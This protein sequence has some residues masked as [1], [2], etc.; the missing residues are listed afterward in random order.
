MQGQNRVNVA[1]DGT[2]QSTTTWRGY[3][4]VDE[5][6]YIDADLIG[7]V[8]IEKGP[9]GG[10]TGAGITGGV[11]SMRTL[12]AGDIVKDGETIGGRFRIGTS[13]NAIE[14][15]RTNSLTQ[16]TDAPGFFD[17]ANGSGS[18]AVAI[19][20]ENFEFVA[21]AAR[22]K[23]GNYFTGS[24]GPTHYE[25]AWG[26][27]YPLSYTQPGE[28]MFNSSEDTFSSLI[29]S[30]MRWDAHTLELGYMHF[31]S[32]FGE[33]LGSLLTMGENSFRQVKLATASADTYTARYRW[34]PGDDMFDVRANIWATDVSAV[35]RSVGG[36]WYMDPW[37]TPEM[38]PPADD[39]RY[40]ETW[41]YGADVTNTSRFGTG[42]G[43]VSIDYG[44]SYVLEDMDGKPYYSR[45]YERDT[46]VIMNPSIGTREVA[47]LFT[48]GTLDVTDWLQF[49]GGLRYDAYRITEKGD[50]YS[51][52]GSY[53][54]TYADQ[55]GGRLNPSLGVTVT[56]F[57]GAQLYALYSE[58]VRPPS[59][60]ETIGSDSLFAPNPHLRA[61]IAKNWEVGANYQRDGLLGDDD[62]LGLKLSYFHNTYDDYIARVSN[63]DPGPGRPFYAAGNL[64]SASF[65]GIELSGSYE[66]GPVFAQAAI[67]HYL[68][69]EFCE[70]ADTC[71]PTAISNDYA[72]NHLPPETAASLTLG[73]KL[74]DDKLTVGGRVNYAGGRLGPPPSSSQATNYWLPYTVVDAFL[75]YE[76]N[77]NV[78][79]DLGVEN[80]FDR[81]YI[82]ALD[83]WMPAPG[84]TIRASMTASF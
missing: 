26:S 55:Q 7:G 50:G 24:E 4:G 20:E 37:Y 62:K 73:V 74:L 75:T 8:S 3:L 2:Q 78:Q 21:A 19:K 28:E 6:V 13:D 40:S 71:G 23:T 81:Y 66:I 31:E 16:R 35:T 63:P 47:S 46:P 27:M 30:T 84:R 42:L 32:E 18:G 45:L 25:N 15:A 70:T 48:R 34:N 68:D 64:D 9:T 1:I 39:P 43:D 69:F 36:A 11:V 44:A 67:T 80:L 38:Y 53:E 59:L 52:G 22:R 10:A 72:N 60:R 61:E 41:T 65:T 49:S 58:G 79:L 77:D 51:T 57:E 17:F 83:G 14:S 5:R 56:P 29:K 54:A 76:V 33:S 82:D 12:N